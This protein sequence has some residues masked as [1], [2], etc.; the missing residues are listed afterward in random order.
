MLSLLLITVSPFSFAYQIE[1]HRALSYW[2]AIRPDSE[3]EKFLQNELLMPSG[4]RTLTLSH[5]GVTTSTDT[6]ELVEWI[7]E[8]AEREDDF[9]TWPNGRFVNHFYNPVTQEGLNDLFFGI[10]SGQKLSSMTWAWKGQSSDRIG[11]W[12]WQRARGAYFG[13]LTSGY[14]KPSPGIS[15][16]SRSQYAGDTFRALGQII[17]LIQDATQP[18]HTRNDAHTPIEGS[19]FEDFCLEKYGTIGTL[20]GFQNETLPSFNY[21]RLSNNSAT[22]MPRELMAFWDTRQY[23]GQRDWSYT[24]S[25]GA[26]EFSNSHFVTDDTMFTGQSMATFPG[27]TI[28]MEGLI[29]PQHVLPNP[30]LEDT[31][32]ALQLGIGIFNLSRLGDSIIS[33]PPVSPTLLRNIQGNQTISIPKLATVGFRP[34]A[35]GFIGEMFLTPEDYAEHAKILLPKA[36]SYS[37]GILRYFFR[38]KLGVQ[39]LPKLDIPGVEVRDSDKPIGIV[40]T[41]LSNEIIIGG[42]W[43]MT[44]D[45]ND[46]PLNRLPWSAFFTKMPFVVR[47]ATGLPVVVQND[48]GYSGTLL[49][50]QSF[51]AV[52]PDNITTLTR[53]TQKC[54][55][56]FQGTIGNEKDIAVAAKQFD[57]SNRGLTLPVRAED[58]KI[59]RSGDGRGILQR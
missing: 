7:Q 47:A 29:A 41:N 6:K 10:P 49:P 57:P 4:L 38:G 39:V 26:A 11:D 22:G 23:R 25:L 35:N 12:S 45:V 19:P 14:E 13:M 15:T 42:Q 55:I 40:V 1:T 54:Q 28:N 32:I 8:G 51:L 9:T 31:D 44:I 36:I 18:Q 46:G 3:V 59:N 2:A 53:L 50:G 16:G 37:A 24:G 5:E 58:T 52:M 34:G 27:L 56:I 48:N 20:E 21:S 33:P 30:K 43:I 17:H